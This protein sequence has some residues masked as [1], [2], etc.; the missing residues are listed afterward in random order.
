LLAGFYLVIDV[1]GFR[2]WAFPLRV[3]GMNSIA[4]YCLAHYLIRGFI[5]GSFKTHLGKDIFLTWG[6]EYELFAAGVAVLAVDW[7]ILFWMYRRG[8]LLRI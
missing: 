4:A 5:I 7:L 1:A 8:I 2:A 6:K 3:I